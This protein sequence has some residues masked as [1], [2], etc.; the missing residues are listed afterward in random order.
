M[1]D[2]FQRYGLSQQATDREIWERVTPVSMSREEFSELLTA[3]HRRSYEAGMARGR[4]QRKTA[5]TLFERLIGPMRAVA[6]EYG[7]AL[8][9]HGSLTR[10]V[11]WAGW[12]GAVS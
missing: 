12:P 10:D 4:R 11:D 1:T 5:K 2:I 6:R 3:L 7:Y 8:A 9:V